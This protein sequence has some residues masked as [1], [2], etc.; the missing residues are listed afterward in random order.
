[1]DALKPC[2]CCGSITQL[3]VISISSLLEEDETPSAIFDYYDRRF[4]VIC[5]YT[6]SGVDGCGVSGPES[7]SEENAALY[8]NN[9]E[10]DH[11]STRYRISD[12]R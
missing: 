9:R 2:P 10:S 6:A 11:S 1:M 3:R 7:N 12:G 4:T 8:W 5:S